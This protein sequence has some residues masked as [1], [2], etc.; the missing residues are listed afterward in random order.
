MILE[1]Y[2]EE[3]RALPPD[4]RA[5]IAHARRTSRTLLDPEPPR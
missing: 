5:L 2:E 1:E 3:G 4:V